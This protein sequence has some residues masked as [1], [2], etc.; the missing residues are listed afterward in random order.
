M[1]FSHLEK[2]LKAKQ[3]AHLG[4]SVS[5]GMFQAHVDGKLP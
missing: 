1:S 4:E 3:K 5:T 2:Q